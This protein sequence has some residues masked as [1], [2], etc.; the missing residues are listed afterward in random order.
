M[1]VCI[2][3]EHSPRL[4]PLPVRGASPFLRSHFKRTSLETIHVLESY[5]HFLSPCLSIYTRMRRKC[6]IH[7]KKENGKTDFIQECSALH[8]YVLHRD[9]LIMGFREYR[10]FGQNNLVALTEFRLRV[11]SVVSILG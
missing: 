3:G 4:F 6:S 9:C 5:S 2:I 10:A 11:I 1:H 8:G 7:P